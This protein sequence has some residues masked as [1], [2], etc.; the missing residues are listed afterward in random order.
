MRQV[1]IFHT[2]SPQLHPQHTHNRGHAFTILPHETL[3]LCIRV[4]ESK[5]DFHPAKICSPSPKP[6]LCY[7]LKN[8]L[9]VGFKCKNTSL[10]NLL[11]IY[12]IDHKF[13]SL[14]TNSVCTLHKRW[15]RG[16]RIWYPLRTMF[17][18]SN[19]KHKKFQ[20]I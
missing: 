5:N 8:T 1:L 3:L 17:V 11:S 15:L 18:M 16:R 19:T 20:T 12:G 10:D 4:V 9:D 13:V 14:S 6:Q 2:T 7:V